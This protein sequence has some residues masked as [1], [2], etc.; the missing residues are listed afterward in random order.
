M[1]LK[2]I[3]CITAALTALILSTGCASNSSTSASTISPGMISMKVEGMACGN[4]AKDIE[5]H[6]LEVKGVKA[7]TVSFEK[8]QATVTLDESNPATLAQ[9]NAAVDA[10]RKDHFGVKEDPNCLDPAKREEIKANSS[11]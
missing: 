9:L 7:A 1:N 11:K 10:W 5:H 4:C 3:L 2:S 8:K 6:L